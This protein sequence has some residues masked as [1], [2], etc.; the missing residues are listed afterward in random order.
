MN[1]IKGVIF[2]KD[3]TLFDF[4]ATWEP[5]SYR[6][7]TELA[8]GDSA[9][10]DDIAQAMGY[11]LET[12]KFLPTSPFIAG[13]AG[14][15]AELLRPFFPDMTDA[16]VLAHL[17]K[18]ATSAPQAPAVP[19]APLLTQLRGMGLVLGVAT[20]DSEGPARAHLAQEGVTDF[21]DAIFGYD[22]GHGAKPAPGQLLAFA[23]QTGLDPAQ[24]VMVGDSTHDL[25]A[26]RAAGMQTAAV[27]TGPA[28]SEALRAYA[29]VILPDIGHLPGWLVAGASRI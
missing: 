24:I 9:K 25:R 13:S 2:D 11:D 18:A 3:G 23:T 29:D 12:R 15:V 28:P 7:L 21:F 17:D 27:L 26:G 16:A 22:S 6:F 1:G 14:E 5:W 19:L 20:N 8:A 4:A 10:Q